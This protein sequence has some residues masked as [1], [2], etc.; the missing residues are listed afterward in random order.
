MKNE[1]ARFLERL[2]R[3]EDH[4]RVMAEELPPSFN[5]T[6]AVHILRTARDLK[7]RLVSGELR[8]TSGEPHLLERRAAEQAVGAGERLDD[9]EVVVA[10]RHQQP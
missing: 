5:K 9:L 10:L 3:I 6:R 8:L 1:H 4:S 2:K 7:R